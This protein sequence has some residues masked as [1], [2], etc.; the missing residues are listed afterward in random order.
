MRPPDPPF[1][2]EFACF[3]IL[4]VPALI[5]GLRLARWI[6]ALS[7]EGQGRDADAR[8]LR[9]QK[10]VFFGRMPLGLYRT[11]GQATWFRL[12]AASFRWIPVVVMILW[13]FRLFAR[14]IGYR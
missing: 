2:V 11:P 7:P 10:K 12:C 3:A 1:L 5:A 4:G 6:E 8:F 14:A 9:A 13:S